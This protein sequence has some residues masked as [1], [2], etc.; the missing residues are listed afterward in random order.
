MRPLILKTELSLDGFVGYEGEEPSWP[1]KYYDDELTAYSVDLLSSAGVHAMGR[2]SYEGMAPHWQAS[3]AP[4]AAPMNEIPKAVFSTTLHEA[5]WPESTIY[6]DVEQG[7]AEL[8][9]SSG[10]PILAHGGARFDQTLTRLDLVDE[11][12][13]IVHPVV[14]GD[15]HKLFGGRTELTLQS[16]RTFQT[17]SVVLTYT[18]S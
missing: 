13:I 8:K 6:R 9:A 10:G 15:G 17:G 12:R 16:A 11:Y 2:V 4:F 1:L 14:F 3:T 18:R 5:T 7:I